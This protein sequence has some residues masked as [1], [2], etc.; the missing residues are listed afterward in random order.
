MNDE[1]S[2]EIDDNIFQ[3][4]GYAYG[5]LFCIKEEKIEN[6]KVLKVYDS[7]GNNIHSTDIV[8]AH[9]VEIFYYAIDGKNFCLM[10]KTKNDPDL[11][12]LHIFGKNFLDVCA[13]NFL[14]KQKTDID[15]IL[16]LSEK[17]RLKICANPN[18]PTF[19]LNE[20]MGIGIDVEQIAAVVAS[21]PNISYDTLG[22]IFQKYFKDAFTNFFKR[23]KI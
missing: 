15:Y 12:E 3:V 4:L 18:T 10:K 23:T 13:E 9:D 22:N 6:K 19:I 21:N 20:I 14:I 1:G 11:H 5:Y 8:N 7:N 16:S 17:E 2:S